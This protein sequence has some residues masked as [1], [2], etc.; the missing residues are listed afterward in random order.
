MGLLDDF[1]C[2]VRRLSISGKLHVVINF[3]GVFIYQQGKLN[4][5]VHLMIIVF[6]VRGH[7]LPLSTKNMIEE[8]AAR[9]SEESG[10]LIIQ[11]IELCFFGGVYEFIFEGF[12]HCD[13][14]LVD[15]P[16]FIIMTFEL[17]L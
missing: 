17:L 1:C 4:R 2:H 9:N 7:D 10:V 14:I 15:S 6:K 12:I 16:S 11:L 5:I 3:L 8:I 13:R